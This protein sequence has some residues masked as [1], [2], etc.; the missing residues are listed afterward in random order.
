MQVI[1]QTKDKEVT[2]IQSKI[3]QNIK[4]IQNQQIHQ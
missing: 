1:T 3:I 2:N 4:Y